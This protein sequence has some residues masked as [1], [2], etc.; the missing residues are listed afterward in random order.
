MHR[1]F[2]RLGRPSPQPSTLS[3]RPCASSWR[4]SQLD[5]LVDQL[6]DAEDLVER[7][8]TTEYGRPTELLAIDWSCSML[9][10]K[11]SAVRLRAAVAGPRAA[12][13]GAA[14][15]RLLGPG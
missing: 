14:D 1:L 8:M 4:L 13:D 6:R 5:A 2:S 7:I 9:E 10:A 15:L 3:P 12:G 11:V